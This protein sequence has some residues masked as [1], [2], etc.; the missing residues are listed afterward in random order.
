MELMEGDN[1]PMYNP[2]ILPLSIAGVRLILTVLKIRT[3]NEHW[4]QGQ[5]LI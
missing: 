4:E 5:S 2:H 1:T 3:F